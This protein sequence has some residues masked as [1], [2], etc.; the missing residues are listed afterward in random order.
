[1]KTTSLIPTTWKTST[2]DYLLNVG[3]G[4]SVLF[5]ALLGG[6]CYQTFC[7]RQYERKRQG[8]F[9]CVAVLD[10]FLFDEFHC[11][12]CWITWKNIQKTF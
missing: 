5:N 2:S 1:M 12:G 11:L 8:L 4:I 6:P 7:A 3:I 10:F 9:N